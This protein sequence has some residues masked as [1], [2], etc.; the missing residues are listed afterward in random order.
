[1]EK[2]VKKRKL[3]EKCRSS[4]QSLGEREGVPVR[5][6]EGGCRSF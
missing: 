4:V 6:G 3:K 2:T 5:T 1:M